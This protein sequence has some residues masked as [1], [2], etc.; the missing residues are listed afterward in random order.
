M[1]SPNTA[2]TA[3][4]SSAAPKLNRSEAT[5]LGA[6]TT[7]QKCPQPESRLRMKVADKGMRMMRDRYSIVYPRVKPN[8]GITGR[9]CAGRRHAGR[10]G[11]GTGGPV[12]LPSSADGAALL[13]IDSIKCAVIREMRRLRSGPA[14]ESGIDGHQRDIR[15]LGRI[16]SS[17]FRIAWTVEMLGGYFLTF[18]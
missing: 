2:L 3:A 16:L 17:D 12:T 6:V 5:T 11:P 15:K 9:P 4:A 7:A 14:A 13:T 1:T 8:P 18:L 10:R